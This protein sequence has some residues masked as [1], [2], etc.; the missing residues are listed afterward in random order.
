MTIKNRLG[1]LY[2][3]IMPELISGQCHDHL[4]QIMYT[5]YLILMGPKK[6]LLGYCIKWFLIFII[7]SIVCIYICSPLLIILALHRFDSMIRGH[8]II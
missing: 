6:K 7:C 1:F 4:A 8:L 3:F 2:A 5:F